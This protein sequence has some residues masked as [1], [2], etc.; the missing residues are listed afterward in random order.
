[1][2]RSKAME[3]T[4]FPSEHLKARQRVERLLALPE[5]AL[6]A[7]SR[8]QSLVDARCILAAHYR[9]EGLQYEHIGQ[10]LG[11]DHST[12]VYY[13]KK[14]DMHYNTSKEYKAYADRVLQSLDRT[15]LERRKKDLIRKIH[16]LTEELVNLSNY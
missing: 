14:H 6:L 11:K 7:P 15:E 8:K 9:S 12:A 10:L 13:V 1:M 4:T 16:N 3:Q 5:G 2:Y